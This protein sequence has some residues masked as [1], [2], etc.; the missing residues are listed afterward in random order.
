[1]IPL[2]EALKTVIIYG[3]AVV[4]SAVCAW[5]DWKSHKILNKV[6]INT[7]IAGMIINGLLWGLPGIENSVAGFAVGFVCI[8]FYLLGCLK[9]G[10][11]K[12]YMA[13]GTLLG[14]RQ[15]FLIVVYSIVIGGIAGVAV[16]LIN[17]NGRERFRKLWVYMKNIF[18]TKSVR[19]YEP[20]GKGAYFSFGICIF[21]AVCAVLLKDLRLL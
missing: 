21:C 9:A 10:D 14:Y 15:L 16:M 5:T 19:K 12:L 3:I 20:E 13:L 17:R 18:W 6:T 1:M 11:I 4:I 7:A 8:I 2:S